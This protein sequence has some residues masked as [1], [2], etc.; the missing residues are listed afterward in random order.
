M[1]YSVILVNRMLSVE[2][3]VLILRQYAVECAARV[4]ENKCDLRTGQ[5][6]HEKGD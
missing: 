5:K 6:K 2:W 3:L 4:I 1:V